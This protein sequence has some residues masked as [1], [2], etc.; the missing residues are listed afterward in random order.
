MIME[1]DDDEVP[2][3]GNR[4]KT[5]NVVYDLFTR[6]GVVKAD[7]RDGRQYVNYLACIEHGRALA[8]ANVSM[9]YTCVV[10]LECISFYLSY[11]KQIICLELINIFR[12]VTHFLEKS[13]QFLVFTRPSQGVVHGRWATDENLDIFFVRSG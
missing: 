12:F 5:S 8:M 1:V 4:R 11:T 2:T 10:S 7:T 3:E 6:E 13:R 9:R